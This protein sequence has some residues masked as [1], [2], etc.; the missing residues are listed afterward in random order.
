MNKKLP[1]SPSDRY[2]EVFPPKHVS[3]YMEM[4]R[5]KLGVD[6]IDLLQ[7][8]VWDGNWASDPDFR[9]TVAKL[10]TEGQIHAFGL[11]LKRW[12]RA[13]SPASASYF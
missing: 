10:K 1:G 7:F 11:G 5:E 9:R 6:S 4:I 3:K 8:Y 12:D 13:P 2:G